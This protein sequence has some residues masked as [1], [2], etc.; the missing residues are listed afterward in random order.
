MLLSAMGIPDAVFESKQAQYFAQL[1]N[2]RSHP[3]TALKFLM[4]HAKVGCFPM[5]LQDRTCV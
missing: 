4:T 3:G 2:L 1:A 5:L